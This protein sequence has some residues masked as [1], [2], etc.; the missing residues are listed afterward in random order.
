MGVKHAYMN[1]D[2][3]GKIITNLELDDNNTKDIKLCR[4][5]CKVLDKK[6]KAGT[7]FST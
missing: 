2:F 1:K 6:V 3:M 5:K 4:Q 7:I